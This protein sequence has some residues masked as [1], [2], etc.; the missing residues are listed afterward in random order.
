MATRATTSWLQ[1]HP[2]P[3]SS[4][5][6][7]H[8]HSQVKEECE[9]VVAEL[10]GGRIQHP[11]CALHLRG[12]ALWWVRS[13]EA[14]VASEQRRYSGLVV[15]KLVGAGWAEL[16]R[17]AQ[18]QPARPWSRED[19]GGFPREL[20]LAPVTTGALAR[21]HAARWPAAPRGLQLRELAPDLPHAV[22]ELE[23]WI[24]DLETL[25][26]GGL[27]ASGH[28]DA[29][30][31]G[32]R[33]FGHYL[34][35]ACAGAK[36][37]AQRRGAW[38]MASEYTRARGGRRAEAFAELSALAKAWDQAS[39]LWELLQTVALS[40]AD[41]ASCDGHAPAPLW[42]PGIVDAGWLWNR[43]LNYWGRGFLDEAA[44]DKLVRLLHGRIVVDH[45]YG[46]EPDRQAKPWR[47]LGRLRWEAL[48]PRAR[49]QAMLEA[50]GRCSP[51]LAERAS[52]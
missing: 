38:A 1:K 37:L 2:S 36:P 34:E 47:Y 19:G 23:T 5:W 32:V 30:R 48:L 11:F 40:D 20:S 41:I 50:L 52:L 6:Q 43:V 21:K 26:R 46:L 39:S 44:F 25:L 10:S 27:I 8:W 4:N 31:S 51:T 29:M 45:L 33:T 24:E 49:V 15:D 16:L 17:C 14:E 12:D 3:S 28:A 9:A 35:L 42:R 7:F 22:A 13:F 18:T